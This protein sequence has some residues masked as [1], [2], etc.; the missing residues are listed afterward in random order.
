MIKKLA[1]YAA[2]LSAILAIYFFWI[3]AHLLD[4]A[5][6]AAERAVVTELR[7]LAGAFAMVWVVTLIVFLGEFYRE[8]KSHS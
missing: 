5:F 6:S 8:D 2:T 3:A 7:V 1:M 4:T